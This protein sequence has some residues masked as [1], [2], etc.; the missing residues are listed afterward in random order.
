[1]IRSNPRSQ[2]PAPSSRGR[3]ATAGVAL[4][5]MLVG[6]PAQA[7][8]TKLSAVLTAVD[9]AGRSESS[10]A[11]ATMAVKT[12][13]YD[14]S[15]TM[16]FW[17][18]GTEKSLIRI[19]EPAKDA[20]V[21]TL[22]VDDNLWNYLPKLDRTMK[23]PAGM[24]SGAWMGSHLSNDDLVRETR[25]SDDYDCTL[26]SDLN[27]EPAGEYVVDCIPHEDA[28]VVWSRV[29]LAVLENLVPREQGFYDD[30][31]RL[32]RTILFEDITEVGGKPTAMT[33]R[34]TPHDKEGEY[35]IFK[36]SEL[37]L[38]IGLDDSMFNLQA[39]RK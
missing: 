18:L 2:L 39:L 3:T 36:F 37:E 33:M 35:T 21:S 24:M 14:R 10:H 17:S 12:R 32:V 13:R 23:V 38:D 28:P 27:V 6:A 31:D 5:A 22:K 29:E 4:V 26:K 9:D 8:D 30:D 19:L 25:F 1:M 20:G 11:K 34:V 16:E 15:L 7:D